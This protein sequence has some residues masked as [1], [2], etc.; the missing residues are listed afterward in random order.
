MKSIGFPESRVA[1]NTATMMTNT[2]RLI[3]NNLL[4][5]KSSIGS[6]L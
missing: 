3:R 1:R 6:V 2:V 4:M 5:K